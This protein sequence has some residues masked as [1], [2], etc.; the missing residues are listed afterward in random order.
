[1]ETM[2]D[3]RVC[4]D[5]CTARL[6]SDLKFCSTDDQFDRA[7]RGGVQRLKEFCEWAIGNSYDLKTALQ[8]ADAWVFPLGMHPPPMRDCTVKNIQT[9]RWDRWFLL[10]CT[11]AC[12]SK[13]SASGK[14]N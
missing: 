9:G 3:L 13:K 7:F 10:A 11:D 12:S 2:A 1:M 14:Q 5:Y 6:E 8:N 4:S